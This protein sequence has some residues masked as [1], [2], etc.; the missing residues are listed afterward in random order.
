MMYRNHWVERHLSK[1][2]CNASSMK[3]GHMC[4]AWIWKILFYLRYLQKLISNSATLT[5]KWPCS[6]LIHNYQPFVYKHWYCAHVAPQMHSF[7]ARTV[8]RVGFENDDPRN[9]WLVNEQT[10]VLIKKK[11]TPYV[12]PQIILITL[13]YFF[14]PK[15]Y[16]FHLKQFR[17]HSRRS[18]Q[19]IHP[20]Y[21]IRR[22]Y[23]QHSSF[24]SIY[25]RPWFRT[26]ITI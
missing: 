21:L 24:S 11:K 7:D 8:H 18:I 6:F 22:M 13:N 2:R 9:V 16:N 20:V 23:H 1:I 5:H 15:S 17:R 19:T 26:V 10:Y 4:N 3:I 25:L 12:H 14:P